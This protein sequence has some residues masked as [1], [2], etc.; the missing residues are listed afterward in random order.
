MQLTSFAVDD[1]YPSPIAARKMAQGLEYGPQEYEG[2][3]YNGIGLGYKLEG[4]ADL[5]GKVFGT[6]VKIDMEYF[7]LSTEVDDLTAYIHADSMISEW[8]AVLYLSEPPP[9]L[10]TGTAFWKHKE[11]GFDTVPNAV[12]IK[13]M[14]P[15]AEHPIDAFMERMKRDWNDES[16][17][18]QSG[19][20]GHK[21]NRLAV[22][23]CR[24]IHSRYPR[25]SWGQDAQNGRVCW[26]AFYTQS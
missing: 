15:N 18:T 4:A 21:F 16:Q 6:T 12:Q 22:Y 20:I 26:T 10:V 3:T 25:L 9:D 14:F 8:A 2:H 11:F 19:M 24:M 23:P 7:R 1:F 5:L 17:W 13:E